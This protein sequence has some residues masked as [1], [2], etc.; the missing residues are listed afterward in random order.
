MMDLVISNFN[1][2]DPR[3]LDI[4]TGTGCIAL[5]LKKA[6]PSAEVYAIDNDSRA[7]QLA[8]ENARKNDVHIHFL[9]MDILHPPPEIFE[10]GFD[11]IVSNP[12]YII[13]SE[14]ILMKQ[15]VLD[16][17]P[18]NALFVDESDPLLFF[19]AIAQFARRRLKLPGDLWVEINEKF[20]RETSEVFHKYGFYKA[21]LL[22]DLQ[23]KNRFIHVK[24]N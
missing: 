12:P 21:R 17:E 7:L 8:E 4:G 18:A 1:R 15:N 2:Q 13:K 6:F 11:L 24:G 5:A 19:R 16:H 22:K 20:G 14:S 10:S 3:I 23:G 9:N